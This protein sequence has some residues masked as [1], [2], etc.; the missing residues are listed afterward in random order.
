M[1]A[2]GVRLDQY[3]RDLAKEPDR[4]G[5]FYVVRAKRIEPVGLIY[6]WPETN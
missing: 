1:R 5:E 2:W 3:D 4:I 6:L